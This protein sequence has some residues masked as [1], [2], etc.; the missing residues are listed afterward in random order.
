[1]DPELKEVLNRVPKTLWT[2]TNSLPIFYIESIP[3]KSGA[4][5]PDASKKS[6]HLSVVMADPLNKEFIERIEKET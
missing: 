1:M 5:E 2:E 3:S 6:S 4:K